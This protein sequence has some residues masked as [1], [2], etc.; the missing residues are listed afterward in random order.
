MPTLLAELFPLLYGLCFLLLLWQAFRVMGRGFRA[1]RRDDASAPS[2]NG[3]RLGKVTI[4][5]ELLDA[6]GQITR[7]DLL[8]VRFSDDSGEPVPP[9][10]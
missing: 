10:E 7:E 6:D 3:N 8:T 5:P 1:M 4:H 2:S 9:I